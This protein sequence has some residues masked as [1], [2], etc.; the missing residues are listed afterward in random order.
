M[1]RPQIKFHAHT[2]ARLTIVAKVTIATG[3]AV[4]LLGAPQSSVINLK[5][6]HIICK[7]FSV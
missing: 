3:P 4:A 2:S 7:I 5:I 1:K 6:Y